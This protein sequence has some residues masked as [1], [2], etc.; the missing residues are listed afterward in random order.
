MPI[1][2][3]SI[4]RKNKWL[5]GFIVCLAVLI[6]LFTRF[7]G[8]NILGDTPSYIDAMNVL[9]GHAPSAGFIP[10]RIITTFGPME[11]IR[12]LAP[13]FGGT[14]PAWF[15]LNVV[16]YLIG[17]IVLFKLLYGFFDSGATAFFG[18]LFL[19]SSYGFFLFGLHYLMDVGG[20]AFYVCSLYFLSRYARSRSWRDILLS[21]LMIGVGGLFKEYAFLAAV[22]IAVYLIVEAWPGL[23]TVSGWKS[24]ASKGIATGAIAMAPAAILYIWAF[25]HFGYTYA[26]WFGA[27]ATHYIYHSRIT[28]YIKSL[29][30]LYN[31]LA[32]IVLG[33]LYVVIKQWKTIESRLRIF[34]VSAAASFLPIFC[35]PAITQRILTATVPFAI[36]IAGFAFKRW[37]KLWWLWAALL[38]M[39]ALATFFM[40]SYILK[41]VNLP[42]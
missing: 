4:I 25:H 19:A 6:V 14:Y 41:A 31:F 28:E 40:D 38:V 20:L 36:I 22:G 27:N 5:V 8:P 12:G 17:C 34:L 7:L 24:F 11:L 29:G 9:A 10:N 1:P 2:I 33:G 30:S 21:A 13:I 26:D 42:F 39:Y 18:G 23:K 37:Q 3:V 35:W 32:L 15:Y 16:L